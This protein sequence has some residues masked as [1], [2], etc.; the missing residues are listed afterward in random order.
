M[1][2]TK[3]WP[4]RPKEESGAAFD[5][6]KVY[7]ENR[8]RLFNYF[9]RC[10]VPRATSEDL[11]QATFLV[12]L[13]EPGRFH[14]DRGSMQVFLIGI[15]RNLRR[16]W[17]R[18]SR[19]ATGALEGFDEVVADGPEVDADIVAIRSAVRALSE[20]AREAIVLR[21]F[22]GMSYEEIARIQGVPVGTIR[23][24]L[25]RARDELRRRMTS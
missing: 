10:G 14:P 16:A 3:D 9:R 23:S 22:H 17:A 4:I 25:A 18:R 24:R 15:A 11:M 20:E 2:R 19:F 12:L 7:E 13:E 8:S 5:P 6:A 1:D 21:E